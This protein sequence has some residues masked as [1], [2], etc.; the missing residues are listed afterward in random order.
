MEADSLPQTINSHH[1]I[2]LEFD[3]VLVVINKDFF[4]QDGKLNAIRHP[5][6]NY[7]YTQLLYQE[8]TRVREHLCIIIEENLQLLSDIMKIFPDKK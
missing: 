8:V 5:N 2:G 6:P 4:Y 7:I 3:Y 1:V